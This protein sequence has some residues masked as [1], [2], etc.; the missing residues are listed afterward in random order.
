MGMIAYTAYGTSPRWS[1]VD[2]S[3]IILLDIRTGRER[4]LTAKGKYFTPDISPDG[5]RV[6]SGFC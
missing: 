6:Y 2:Y 1:L 4:N 5:E 3:D